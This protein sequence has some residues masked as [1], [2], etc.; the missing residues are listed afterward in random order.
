VNFLPPRGIATR[1]PRTSLQLQ[2]NSAWHGQCVK[3]VTVEFTAVE[4]EET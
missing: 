3:E 4:R 2:R 1:F